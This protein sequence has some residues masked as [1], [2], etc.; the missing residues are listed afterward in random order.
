M[1]FLLCLVLTF[2]VILVMFSSGMFFFFLAMFT[3]GYQCFLLCLTMAISVILAMLT[4]TI[5]VSLFM[6]SPG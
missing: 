5:S 4:F 2:S 3:S 1:L 6:V